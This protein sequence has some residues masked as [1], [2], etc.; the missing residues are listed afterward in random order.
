[1]RRHDRELARGDLAEVGGRHHPGHAGTLERARGIDP[2]NSRVGVRAAHDRGVQHAGQR[3]VA[4]VAPT[5]LDEPRVFLAEE[6]VADELHGGSVSK[7][8][9]LTNDVPLATLPS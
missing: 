3:Y 6:P 5:A 1:M 2:E 4:D 7:R 8:R 9:R